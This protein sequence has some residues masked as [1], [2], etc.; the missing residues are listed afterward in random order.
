MTVFVS[1]AISCGVRNNSYHCAEEGCNND[2]I[3][4]GS[5][6]YGINMDEASH[7]IDTSYFSIHFNTDFLSL[8]SVLKDY[9]DSINIDSCGYGLSFCKGK[10]SALSF[11]Y[12]NHFRNNFI[13][14]ENVKIDVGE[15]GYLSNYS[16]VSKLYEK[17]NKIRIK[18]E[19]IVYSTFDDVT[20]NEIE[21]YAK[22]YSNY[23]LNNKRVFL[24]CKKGNITAEAGVIG[25]VFE[26]DL[27][28][29]NSIFVDLYLLIYLAK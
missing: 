3:M 13:R 25:R 22:H 20:M 7:V 12:Y 1:F 19:E 11:N 27:K 21:R 28:Y 5:L 4:F 29:S 23:H 9:P 10:L 16:D 6:K 18:L 15:Y 17:L 8:D 24:L 14:V 2:S 26:E